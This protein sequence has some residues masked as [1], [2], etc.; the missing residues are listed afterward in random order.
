MI[1]NGNASQRGEEVC[2]TL[3]VVST[4]P[5]ITR[6]SLPPTP[7]SS[8]LEQQPQTR[9]QSERRRENRW[10]VH[11]PQIIAHYTPTKRHP[12]IKRE[13]SATSGRSDAPGSRVPDLPPLHHLHLLLPTV[14][15]AGADALPVLGEEPA[16][17]RAGLRAVGKPC[18]EAVRRHGS[19]GGSPG[20][21]QTRGRRRAHRLR[22]YL[23]LRLRRSDTTPIT[24][25]ASWRRAYCLK[26]ARLL[27]VCRAGVIWKGD[28]LIDGVPET[29]D[30]LRSKVRPKA[31]MLRTPMLCALVSHHFDLDEVMI[32]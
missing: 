24:A 17:Q 14:L 26:L 25:P 2:S 16:A 32:H 19:S 31:P 29:L 30:F 23:H 18:G 27:C 3:V 4:G 1:P 13:Q 8:L 22:R 12:I 9:A 5:H 21:R 28:K 11:K 10:R 20:G 6:L 15:V 7:T